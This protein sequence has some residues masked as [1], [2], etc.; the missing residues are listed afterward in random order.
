MK[1][2]PEQVREAEVQREIQRLHAEIERF[3]RG[4]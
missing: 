4:G 1:R 3:E 2:T